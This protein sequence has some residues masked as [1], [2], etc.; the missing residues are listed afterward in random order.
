MWIFDWFR[1]T[2][3]AF[4]A[5]RLHGRGHADAG[6]ICRRPIGLAELTA[7]AQGC[8]SLWENGFTLAASA[9]WRCSSTQHGPDRPIAG[10]ARRERMADHA[11]L[12]PCSQWDL[13][14]RY[15]VPVAYRISIP[16]AGGGKR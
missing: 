4:C 9:A 1:R 10:G 7:T 8:I 11:R 3:E 2:R 16:E 5:V 13:R 12:V 6:G 14:T 15:A